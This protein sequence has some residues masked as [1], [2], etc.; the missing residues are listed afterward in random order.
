MPDSFRA[1]LF[2]LAALLLVPTA[3]AEVRNITVGE[4]RCTVHYEWPDLLY[5][6][7]FPVEVALASKSDGDLV[8]D[9]EA[10]QDWGEQDLV[11][12]RVPLRAGEK[13]RFELLLRAT[14]NSNNEYTVTFEV[15]GEDKQLRGVG[16][17]EHPSGNERT[18]LYISATAPGAGLT[19]RWADEWTRE[20]GVASST[21]VHI[22]SASFSD[23]PASWEAYSSLDL[24]VIDLTGKEPTE[25]AFGVL[26]AWVRSGGRVVVSGTDAK[27]FVA[28]QP[29]AGGWLEERF[30]VREVR[31]PGT[32]GDF[33]VFRCG[34]GLLIFD[35]A[36]DGDAH[37][38]K[39]AG[40]QES[41][42]LVALDLELHR[43]WGPLGHR[44]SRMDDA[45]SLLAGF[46]QLPLRG[47]M[48]LLVLFA[49]LIGPVNFLW[50]RRMKKPMLLLFTVPAIA[51]TVSIGLVF[52][53]ILSEGLDVKVN[54]RSWSVLDQREN[55]AT[56]AEVRRLFAGSSPGAGLR[57]ARGTAV[58][59]EQ[60]LSWRS[61]Q[62]NI[63]YLQDLT[64]GRLLGGDYMQVRQPFSQLIL[65]DRTSRVRLEAH[66]VSG[67]VEV[68]NALGESVEELLLRTPDGEYHLLDGELA[69]GLDTRLVPTSGI[70][71]SL[72]WNADLKYIFSE[73]A[74][75]LPGTYIASVAKPVLGDDCGVEVREI[76]GRHVVLGVLE[77]AE[78]AWR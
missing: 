49:I 78:E 72:P 26:L 73:R 39:G 69:P 18:A 17:D 51:L 63:R 3:R 50:V 56:T 6:G 48:V 13:V 27:E 1:L 77:L 29:L 67:R 2:L 10:T 57:P 59:P 62:D 65:S 58:F 28:R 35:E 66:Y 54:T 70:S 14:A 11:T 44:S 32:P 68:S 75:L 41:S 20:S 42:G 5:H 31:Q 61:Y 19:A 4:V 33:R 34:H 76:D 43:S 25:E 24:V 60:D 52:Y 8:V 22:G 16:P 23:M 53:G 21:E 38:M 47:Y 64:D 46:G 55:V 36:S 9:V 7:Y 12:R 45:L 37:P 40:A 74:H 71:A 30:E 15:E